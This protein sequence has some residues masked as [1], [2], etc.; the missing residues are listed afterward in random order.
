MAILVLGAPLPERPSCGH[1]G[2]W[3]VFRAVE[4]KVQKVHLDGP[5]GDG[6]GLNSPGAGCLGLPT[7]PCLAKCPFQ[8]GGR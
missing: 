6:E 4:Q 3:R 1:G 8:Q 2:S 5:A 7:C